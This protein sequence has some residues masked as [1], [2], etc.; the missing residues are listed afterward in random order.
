MQSAALDLADSST[1]AQSTTLPYDTIT[2]GTTKVSNESFK[3][4]EQRES[5]Q[6]IVIFND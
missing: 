6:C 3:Q 1:P 2:S 4:A 5:M